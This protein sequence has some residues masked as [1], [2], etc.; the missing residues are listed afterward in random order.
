[1]KE[2][3]LDTRI[4]TIENKIAIKELV[5]TFSLVSDKKDN[6]AQASFFTE[7]G[8]LTSIMGDA[9]FTF[10]GRK[11]IEDGFASI[12]APL[13]TVWHHNG[14]LSITID[15][16]KAT[17]FSYCLAT[18]IGTENNNKYQ[19][20]IAANYADEYVKENEQWLISKRTATV[21]WEETKEVK[22]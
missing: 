20:T 21:A 13:E 9:T 14:Q 18:L 19:R 15:G 16:N 3:D 2:T 8:I 22:I 5:D 1:M 11:E 7:D 4:S 17:G 12:L 10:T 6:V